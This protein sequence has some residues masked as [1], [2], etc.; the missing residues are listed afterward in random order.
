MKKFLRDI[1]H[2]LNLDRE[3]DNFDNIHQNMVKDSVFRGTNL[4]VLMF[5]ILVASVGLN[6][7]S[8]AVIIGAMLISPLMGP[9]NSMG[10]SL[11]TY[12]FSLFRIAIKNYSFAIGLGLTTSTIYFLI[13]P[14][15]SAHSELLARTSPSIYDVLIAM[16]GGVA[17]MVALTSKQKGNVI[18]GVAI[19]T[20]LMPP[21]C[22]A[23]YGLATFQFTF[24]FGALYLFTINT[25]FIAIGALLVSR[26]INLPI[27]HIID[28][29][30]KKRAR[31]LTS[32]IILLTILPSFYFG[33]MLVKKE[34]FSLN[35]SSF[36]RNVSYFHGS[37]L[38]DHTINSSTNTIEMVYGGNKLDDNLKMEL[39]HKAKEFHLNHAEL[40]INQGFT[41]DNPN[42]NANEAKTQ[43]LLNE[44]SQLKSQLDSPVPS[45]KYQQRLAQLS[46]DLEAELKS[47]KPE[48]S[49]CLVS[50]AFLNSPLSDSLEKS[51]LVIIHTNDDKLKQSDKITINNWL[52]NRLKT[53][54]MMV[55][56]E[57]D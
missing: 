47:F 5:A 26:M 13:S 51:T 12:D 4:W 3:L 7:N 20:A 23:G 30:L 56:Y 27:R 15:S 1:L 42:F 34:Q 36:I 40:I 2:Y 21:L 37:Y 43:S 25:V 17:G 14:I 54:E 53:T 31:Q 24:F 35:A 29:N 46:A 39:L 32:L 48:V 44:I 41:L 52:Q 11:A 49:N 57:S 8:T 18:P 33:F 50:E 45:P 19:A 6:M 10:Y 38:I 16:F 9:I 28:P 55:I 22:T